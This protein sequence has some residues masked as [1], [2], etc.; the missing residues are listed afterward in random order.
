L[1]VKVDVKD[2]K[3]KSLE[4]A[5]DR[6]GDWN[7]QIFRELKER[8]TLR[9]L[10]M[11]AGASLL[12]QAFTLF[13]F[14]SQLPVPSEF[15]HPV[16]SK[17][18]N[19]TNRYSEVC[20][21]DPFGNFIIN[22]QHWWMDL[23]STLNWILPLALI[24]GTV[25]MLVADLAQEE[26]R[27]TLNFIRLSPQSPR[28]IAIGKIL[29]V[30]SLVYLAVLLAL[31][32]H[33]LAAINAGA[34]LGLIATELL[35]FGAIW[36]LFA[37]TS[38]LYVL[39]G[40][41]QAILTTLVASYPVCLPLLLINHY[42]NSTIEGDA[43]L[44]SD[45]GHLS[46]FFMTLT[47]EAIRLY[48]FGVGCCLLA[49]YWIWQ[50]LERRYLNPN[51]T[52][53][54]K[55][56]S[57]L[58]TFCLQIWLLGFA[59]PALNY[60][61]WQRESALTTLAIGNFLFLI[62]LIPILLPSKQ[63]LQDWSRYRRERVTH[64]KRAF[65]RQELVQ[66]LISNDKSPALVAIAINM[67]MA[68]VMWLPIFLIVA[69][70]GDQWFKWSAGLFFALTLML[71]YTAIAHL[72]LFLNFKKRQ[73]WIFGGIAVS[74]ILP[75]VFAAMLSGG[76]TPKGLAAVM[77]LFSPFLGIGLLELSAMNILL[78]FCAQLAILGVLTKQLQRKLRITGQS[79]TK[80]LMQEL[81]V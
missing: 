16:Y 77:L 30:P 48:L 5:I 55:K 50:A 26:K 25:Y 39:L 57:Y 64:Q 59:L 19:F 72:G 35:T 68:V 32:L 20:K 2:R 61:S 74:I 1:L 11:A 8:W 18:C 6:V 7:P 63:A 41:F 54:S 12:V 31:P 36:W 27:G 43:W 53:L 42:T 62:L 38:I 9:N 78:T 75:I 52:I 44:N 37:S 28:A 65:W 33:L 66:D 29:G 71:I 24:L 46:W 10:G 67:G 49:S 23:F 69:D 45:R 34:S 13:C 79:Q 73:L 81:K 56:E 51:A 17:Y 58:A 47:N 80:A 40:G 15:K 4:K 3:M 22:W 70:N 21:T 14:W 60:S 76:S